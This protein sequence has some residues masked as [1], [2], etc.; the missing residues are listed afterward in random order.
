MGFTP[1]LNIEVGHAA[2]SKSAVELR[3]EARG[4]KIGDSAAGLI[5]PSCGTCGHCL[6]GDYSLCDNLGRKMFERNGSFCR[7][8]LGAGSS[9]ASSLALT[10]RS[11]P[12]IV[13]VNK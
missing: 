13:C 10:R 1:N 9:S 6:D 11:I 2:L 8:Y 5:Y 7:I 4:F 3:S 12:M